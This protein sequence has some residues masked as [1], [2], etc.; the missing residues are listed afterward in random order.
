MP[1]TTARF[2]E[3]VREL[4]TGREVPIELVA[5][6]TGIDVK[7]LAALE[8]GGV[9]PSG[10]EILILADHFKCDFGFLIEDEVRDVN[11]NLRPLFR[12]AGARLSFVDRYAVAEFLFLCSSQAFLDAVLNTPPPGARF[13]FV[14]RGTYRIGQ[15][16]DCARSLR[17]WLRIRHDEP[18]PT[19]LYGLFRSIGIRV[20]R[21]ALPG[22]PISGLFVEHPEAG[23]CVLVNGTEDLYRQRFS[24][25]HECG[26]ALMD[27]DKA[28]NLSEESDARSM[29][30]IEVR[31]NAFASEF[32]A[33]AELLRKLGSPRSWENPAKLLEEAGALSISVPALL[34]GLKQA[35]LIDDATRDRLRD[36]A[37]RLPNKQD[38]EITEDMAPS[39]RE[40]MRDLLDRGLNVDYVRQCFDAYAHGEMSQGKVAEMLMVDPRDLSAVAELFRVTL[41]HA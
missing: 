39:Q 22:S 2:A 17:D 31:A 14:E 30:L 34:S 26:H 4:R 35:R 8:G 7:R 15:G 5:N 18:P 3:K 41:R 38:P 11:A 36:M 25:A 1:F 28:Y 40:R 19:N 6:S 24:A 23:R 10:D 21:R 27:V 12:A 16:I 32:L 20:F 9:Q 13:R 33:P 29:D 37:L